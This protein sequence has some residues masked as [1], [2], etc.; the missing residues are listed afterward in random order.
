MSKF[1]LLKRLGFQLN[2]IREK[3]IENKITAYSKEEFIQNQ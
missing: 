3:L 1:I 2:L